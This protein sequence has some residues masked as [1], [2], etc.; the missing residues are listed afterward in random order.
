[1]WVII[2]DV[3]EC[4]EAPDSL[5]EAL[6]ITS[7]SAMPVNRPDSLAHICKAKQ[8]HTRCLFT[9]VAPRGDPRTRAL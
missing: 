7:V 9:A 8:D 5:S 6:M 2:P 3:H 1:M 4:H